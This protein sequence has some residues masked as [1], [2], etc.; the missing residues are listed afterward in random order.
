MSAVH[1]EIRK[2]L[3]LPSLLVTAAL[4]AAAALL[5]E[6]AP[7]RQVGFLIFGV[8]S[9][10][11]EF[12]GQF[13]TSLLAVPDR[14]R[15]VAAKVAAL[16]AVAGPLTLLTPATSAYL[17][18]TTLTAAGAGLLLRRTLPSVAVTL[19]AYLIVGPLLRARFPASAPW[20]PDT[21]L[22]QPSRGAAAT[23]VCTMAVLAAAVA[24]LAR[25]DAA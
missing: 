8:L 16:V 20:L 2:L 1:A 21:A 18:A 9:A 24:V 5:P 3:T 22:L 23:V 11:H 15:L 6:P 17:L 7:Y 19:T 14:P 25:R 12:Q 13:R 10:T 4:T